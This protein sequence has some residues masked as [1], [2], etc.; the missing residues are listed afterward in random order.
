M[1]TGHRALGASQQRQRSVVDCTT[2]MSSP[3]W[4]Q[5]NSSRLGGGR[6]GA[7]MCW[8][9]GRAARQ[10]FLCWRGPQ[11]RAVHGAVELLVAAVRR[12]SASSLRVV[13]SI[14]ERTQPAELRRWVD[15]ASTIEHHLRAPAPTIPKSRAPT[16]FRPH[17]PVGGPAIRQARALYRVSPA[18]CNL[19]QSDPCIQFY[20]A[21]FGPFAR[22]SIPLCTK[23][24]LI[25]NHFDIALDT[26]A[27]S[28]APD[29]RWTVS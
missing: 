28:T 16:H 8:R 29:R 23:L 12:P 18:T 11:V 20:P 13:L 5:A 3:M 2:P 27:S 7:G 19:S 17:R 4:A 15:E 21:A 25:Q 10:R 9:E 6:D 22:P 14:H 24:N 1:A 26:N